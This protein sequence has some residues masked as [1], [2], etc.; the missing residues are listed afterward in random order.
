MNTDVQVNNRKALIE[1]RSQS[2]LIHQARKQS[3]QVL[4]TQQAQISSQ[5]RVIKKFCDDLSDSSGRG[6]WIAANTAREIAEIIALTKANKPLSA[7]EKIKSLRFQRLPPED[8][9]DRWK[10]IA[11]SYVSE[12]RQKSVG[13]V[14]LGKV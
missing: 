5:I 6:A 14:A 3:L 2:R 1:S 9:F 4:K 8:V 10:K 12:I 11:G 13:Y 7:V